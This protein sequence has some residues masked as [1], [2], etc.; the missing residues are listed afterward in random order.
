MT[1]H[2]SSHGPSLRWAGLAGRAHGDERAPGTPFVFIH[3]LTFDSRMWDPVLDALPSSHR[4]IAFDLPGHG[5]SAA[6]PQHGGAVIA[7]AIHEAVLDAGLDTPI[8]IGH[9][10]GG[11]LATVYAARYPAAAVVSV[12]APVRLEPFA[13]LLR[14]LHPQ[15]AGDGFRQAWAIYQDSWHMELL[16]AADL[17][18][19][20]AG[21]L[22]GD[23]AL[24]QLV[25]SYQSDLLERPLAEVLRERDEGQR[26]L[27]AAGTPYLTLHAR[28]LDPSDAAWVRERLPQAEILVW[29][30]GHHFPHLTHPARFAALLMGLAAGR[31]SRPPSPPTAFGE[32]ARE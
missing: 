29:P 8:V 20:R 22:P 19:L 15:L 7:D 16:P 3:G 18:L 21:D 25:L 4:G 24:Q 12:E 23:A 27:R 32:R 13:Q 30:V 5:G 6:L 28:P 11:P 17:A 26:R 9:A 31:A 10:I 14:S 2:P 1:Q